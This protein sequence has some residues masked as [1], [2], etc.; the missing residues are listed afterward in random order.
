[1]QLR[2]REGEGGG[3]QGTNEPAAVQVTSPAVEISK[4]LVAESSEQRL[5]G[6]TRAT[7]RMEATGE[8]RA[9]QTINTALA[10]VVSDHK[11]ATSVTPPEQDTE[12]GT[13]GK[14][15]NGD[16]SIVVVDWVGPV[17]NVSQGNVYYAA[18]SVAGVTMRLQDT[19]FFRPENMDVPP[20]IARL[21]VSGVTLCLL[22]RTP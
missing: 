4:N 10:Q 11:G 22:I 6:Q 9:Q 19:A 12:A 5:N 14:D 7:A 13:S 8:V 1:M 21:Q 17:V 15:G 3:A 18:C 2:K 20:Y 16:D